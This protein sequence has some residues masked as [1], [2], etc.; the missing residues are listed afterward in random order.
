MAGNVAAVR[1]IPGRTMDNNRCRHCGS[2]IETLPHV[3]GSCSHGDA[4]RNTRHH[5]VRSAIAQA[6]R[7]AGLTVFEE[8]YGIS[9]T[10]STRR[11]DMI[12]FQ[13]H[14]RGFIIYPTVRFETCKSRPYPAFAVFL[15]NPGKI[16]NQVMD[17]TGFAARRA[18][19]STD[20]HYFEQLLQHLMP[21]FPPGSRTERT[22]TV[23]MNNKFLL[24]PGAYEN[25]FTSHKLTTLNFWLY[26]ASGGR[27][28]IELICNRELDNTEETGFSFIRQRNLLP[29]E[30]GM[31]FLD[32][33]RI[34][35]LSAEQ[36][37]GITVFR[38]S[39]MMS[40]IL[41]RCRT[42]AM[43]AIKSSSSS[44]HIPLQCD[45]IDV[46]RSGEIRNTLTVT[47]HVQCESHRKPRKNLNQVTCTDR[48]SN[49]GHL[50][51]RPDALTVTP[52][53]V[54]CSSQMSGFNVPNYVSDSQSFTTIKNNR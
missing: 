39:T 47:T 7:N 42:A 9:T 52:T 30:T 18:D 53:G 3:L 40:L 51:S 34:P 27:I 28:A 5:K 43:I 49:P 17:E 29:D 33:E 45:V 32:Y 35:N 1:A 10:G 24:F 37:G 11:I 31:L 50:V 6:L 25:S 4:L 22:A 16:L 38:I 15:E 21:L 44:V 20:G 13:D 14:R 8:V 54:D 12:A 46:Q 19:Y 2:E 48:E 36:S 23:T 26:F 41:H